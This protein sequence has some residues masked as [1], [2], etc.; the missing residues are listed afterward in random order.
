MK[1]LI[2]SLI[3]AYVIYLLSCLILGPLIQEKQGFDRSPNQQ[4]I[5]D[6]APSERILCINDNT[7][8][9]L[10]RLRL[11]EAAKEEIILTTFD[12]GA[13]QSGTDIMS[14][15]L[16]AADRGVRVRI[17]VD[18]IY[19]SFKL[20]NNRFDVLVAHEN[21][22][23]KLYNTVNLLTA[24][25]INYRL[26]DKY[27]IADDRIY[28]LGGRNTTDLFLG[29][30]SDKANT[31]RDVLV[32]REK[33]D[34][35]ASV[36]QLRQYF[37]QVWS[38]SC[39]KT[40]KCNSPKETAKTQLSNRYLELQSKYPE[41]FAEPDWIGETIPTNSVSL[42]C[43]PI[44][45]ANKEPELWNA[46]CALMAKGKDVIIQTP[47]VI[48][49]REMYR[50]FSEITQ[51]GTQI[52]I[53]LNAVANGANPWGCTD[54]LN[55]KDN[56]LKTGVSV[57]EY[58]GDQSLHTKTLLIDNNISII[59]SFNMD[60][61]SVYLDTETMLVIDCPELN[62]QLRNEAATQMD[63]SNH[64]SSDGTEALGPN[65]KTKSFGIPKTIFYTV[66]RFLIPP[67][68]HIL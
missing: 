34:E 26:H 63:A 43:N 6:A 28:M 44:S 27:L 35:N 64:V 31:D 65:C 25:D 47:Y 37:E 41:S 10:W 7:D 18:G 5:D 24:W 55:Q 53:I 2:V 50:G 46:L 62:A 48:C 68:R 23:V 11:I 57:C 3:I 54:Y 8:A 67:I 14:A 32:Y 19:G 1:K 33:S 13:D 17:L 56:I 4:T 66:L 30:Y 51:S 39:N 29:D 61:R 21:I 45:N 12:F 16:H 36:Y 40:L 42:I 60:M 38:L 15:L 52:T 22:E 49:N 58:Y 20:H 9:L 59:G